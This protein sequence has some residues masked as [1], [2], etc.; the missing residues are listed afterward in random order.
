MHSEPGFPQALLF[1]M[2]GLTVDSEPYWFRSEF[3][4][5]KSMGLAWTKA[6]HLSCVGGPVERMAHLIASRA[7]RP[8]DWEEVAQRTTA[9][10]ATLAARGIKTNPGITSLVAAAR[11]RGIPVALVSG[12][13]RIVVSAIVSGLP[14]TYDVV[15]SSDDVSMNKPSPEPYLKAASDLGVDITGC[16]A[17]EDSPTGAR[18]A[19]L[20]GAWVFVVPSVP[21]PPGDRRIHLST[22]EGVTLDRL[23]EMITDH[24]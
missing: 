8:A 21:V 7:G 14:I 19:E 10:V 13:P 15:V 1:D 11:E 9:G 12:S 2:D 6:D 23:L 24:R 17:F 4:V 18:S 16:I 22:L 5:A 3:E 20:A